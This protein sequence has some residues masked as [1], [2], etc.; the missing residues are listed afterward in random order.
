M[1]QELKERLDEF[2]TKQISPADLAKYL[3]RYKEETI[4]MVIDAEDRDCIYMKWISDGVYYLTSICEILDP[5]LED[6]K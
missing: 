2:L 3:R 1:E 4:R 5:Y 6:T